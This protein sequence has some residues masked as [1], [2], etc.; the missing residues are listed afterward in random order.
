MSWLV[1]I[2]SGKAVNA[3]LCERGANPRRASIKF[4]R[5]VSGVRRF[6]GKMVKPLQTSTVNPLK[7]TEQ[8]TNLVVP[9]LKKRLLSRQSLLIFYSILVFYRDFAAEFYLSH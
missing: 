4:E 3:K 2:Y 9:E 8:N 5:P 7:A 1:I 6:D